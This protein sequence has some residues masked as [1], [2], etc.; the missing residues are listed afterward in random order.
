MAR[1]NCAGRTLVQGYD[2]VEP[3][4]EF[5]TGVWPPRYQP[6]SPALAR[7][8][9]ADA[10]FDDPLIA[11]PARGYALDYA[12]EVEVDGRKMR[13]VLETHKLTESFSLLIEPD[14]Y[15]ITI[16][17]ESRTS[18]AG[19]PLLI[20]TRYGQFQPVAGVLHPH[21]ITTSMDGRVSQITRIDHI[22]PNPEITPETFSALKTVTAPGPASR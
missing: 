5:D 10:E 21:E 22:E 12:G 14:T 2:G 13:R 3:P 7:R 17:T 4:W 1:P 11:G 8:I 16:R 18:A 15:L 20:V 6:V 19:R 9:I